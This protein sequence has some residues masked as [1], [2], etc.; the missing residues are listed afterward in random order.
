LRG[1]PLGAA[2]ALG[3]VACLCAGAGSTAETE[4]S[5]EVYPATEA[6]PRYSE[7][8][9]VPLKDGRLLFAIT[10][11]IEDGS[12]FSAAHIVARTS[13]DGGR[14]WGPA[15]LLQEN[16]GA[17]NVMSV[18]LRRLNESPDRIAFFYL[19]KHSHHELAVYVRFSMDE[20]ETFGEPVLVSGTPGYHVMNNDRVLQLRGGR[21]LAPVASTGDARTEN[22]Y[23][24]SCYLSDDQG[25]TWRRSRSEVD[26]AKRG[27]MEPEVIEMSDGRV[28]MVFRTQLGH[29]GHSISEDGG[30]TWSAPVSWG[31]RAPEAPA[32]LRNIPSTG[33]WL[34]VWN[35]TFVE[36][37]GHGGKRRPL[38]AAIS[39]DEG[40]TWEHQRILDDSAGHTFAYTSLVFHEDR[41]LISYYVAEDATGRIST[42]FRS[43]PVTWFYGA[44]SESA[45]P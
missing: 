15:R 12:D 6:N 43:L 24:A 45:L 19:V 8:S 5:T 26:Y 21:L 34:L 4:I 13:A 18:T 31:V 22:H 2:I 7:G 42:R 11:F 44:A 38:N 29:I 39:R 25:M 30:D 3:L 33:D 40:E 28:L 27:A 9:I 20:G 35:D 16:V 17:H 32:T 37:E 41:A 10:E 14:T 23:V 1:R 36:G